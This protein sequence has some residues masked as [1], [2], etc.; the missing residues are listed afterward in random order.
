MWTEANQDLPKLGLKLQALYFHK[1]PVLAYSRCSP[2]RLH[3]ISGKCLGWMVSQLMYPT[4][5]RSRVPAIA[6]PVSS[7]SAHGNTRTHPQAVFLHLRSSKMIGMNSRTSKTPA[8][9]EQT[10]LILHQAMHPILRSTAC[11]NQTVSLEMNGSIRS[12]A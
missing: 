9:A 3:P 12:L 11:Q 7:T 2:I 5:L 10:R 1:L 8:Q 6:V 4:S